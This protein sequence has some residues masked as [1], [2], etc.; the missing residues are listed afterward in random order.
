MKPGGNDEPK[1]WDCSVKVSVH[2]ISVGSLKKNKFS[3]F[4]VP[5]SLVGLTLSILAPK[6]LP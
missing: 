1:G 2:F 5:L 4:G 6:W 3:A